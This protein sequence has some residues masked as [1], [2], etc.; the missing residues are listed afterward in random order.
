M[1]GMP[2]ATGSLL[3]A[4]HSLMK[5]CRQRSKV[6]ANSRSA[7]SSVSATMIWRIMPMV[8]SAT[9]AL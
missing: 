1:V 5:L 8:G 6:S 9:W 4:T 7:S 3:F 2:T